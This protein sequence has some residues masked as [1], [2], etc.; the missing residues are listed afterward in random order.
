MA[1]TPYQIVAPLLALLALLYAW[2]LVFRGK[3]SVW[4]AILWTLFWGGV[5]FIAF[6]PSTLS[7]LSTLTGIKNQ[8]NAIIVTSIGI[9]FF[10]VFYIIMRLE[11]VRQQQAR[12]IRSIGLMEAGLKDDKNPSPPP[13][14]PDFA[15]FACLRLC[16]SR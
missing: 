15:Y 10:I 8:E 14:F 5:A 1:L 12:I 7:Y 16:L 4:E 2:N 6:Y 13:L 3:K 9:L 11:E